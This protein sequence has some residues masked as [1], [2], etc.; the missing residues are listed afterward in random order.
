MKKETLAKANELNGKIEVHNSMNLALDAQIASAV[1]LRVKEDDFVTIDVKA[2][3]LFLGSFEGIR[4][5]EFLG[6]LGYERKYHSE[7]RTLNNKLLEDLK[8]D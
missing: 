6:L 2:G 8:E 7:Q 5:S 3:N 4:A 1:T